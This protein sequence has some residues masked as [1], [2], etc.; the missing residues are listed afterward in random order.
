M[1]SYMPVHWYA[2]LPA[3]LNFLKWFWLV[4]NSALLIAG[5]VILSLM[6]IAL[7][8]KLGY[9][10]ASADSM[11]PVVWVTS[12]LATVV[13]ALPVHQTIDDNLTVPLTA[14]TVG[15]LLMHGLHTV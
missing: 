14:A 7:F 1:V 10:A 6:Y 5:G 3:I 12:L 15:Q 8:H 2:M 11:M 4:R 13:E 9:I